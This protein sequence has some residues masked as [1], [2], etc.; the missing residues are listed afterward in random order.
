[1]LALGA[2]LFIIIKVLLM[3]GLVLGGAYALTTYVEQPG[4]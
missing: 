4:R 1:M 2:T 3:I